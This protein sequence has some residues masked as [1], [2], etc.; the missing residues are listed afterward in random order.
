MAKI[1]AEPDD[2]HLNNEHLEDETYVNHFRVAIFGSAR[3]K[4]EQ[5]YYQQVFDL[6]KIVGQHG[7]DVITGGGPGLMNAANEGHRAGCMD[8]DAH[9]IG[10]TI[11]LP[12]ENKPNR[13][14]DIHEHFNRFSDRLDEFLLLSNAAIFTH[15]G[16]GTGLEFFYVWQH[17]QVKH[18]SAIPMILIGSMW[19]GLV[20]W[21]I[22]HPLRLGLISSE[23]FK[24]LFVV[25]TNEEAMEIVMA[26]HAEYAKQGYGNGYVFTFDKYRAL[27]G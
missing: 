16:V 19:D 7:F 4:P 11:Q 20:K 22:E 1:I 12:W 25:S 26:A 8:P 23:D 27:P 6:A 2:H 24:Q 5:P 13:N 15:G 14:L 10:L 3:T 9:S 21:L 18:I 17:I